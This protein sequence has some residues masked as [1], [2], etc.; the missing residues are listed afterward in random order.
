MHVVILHGGEADDGPQEALAG[1]LLEEIEHRGWSHQLLLLRNM[2]I[3]PCVGCFGCWLK[4]PGE[5][6]RNDGGRDV[7]RALVQGDAWV[8]L[9]RVTFG[10]YSS[11]LKSALD[12]MIPNILPF[13]TVRQ[14]DMR[15]LLRYPDPAVL[16]GLGLQ[17]E[18]DDESASIFGDLIH[19][20]ALNTDAPASATVVLAET[21]TDETRSE[22]LDALLKTL[23]VAR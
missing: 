15:H 12:R 5:C 1:S 17:R 23:E 20:N 21:D 13:F 2:T 14:G 3:A 9:S 11:L 10:G 16:L 7:A 19:R 8:F 18:A 4:T 6:I 22:R